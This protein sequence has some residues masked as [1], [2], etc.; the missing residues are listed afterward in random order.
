MT[1]TS[2]NTAQGA[3]F[4]SPKAPARIL[5]V[6]DHPIVRN[7]LVQL[8]EQEQDLIVCA[9]AGSAHEAE[10]ALEKHAPHIAMLDISLEG[11]NGIEL[12]RRIR[13]LYPETC[14][15]IL[16]MHDEN[17]YAKRA[18][19]AGARGYVTKQ[20]PPEHVVDAIRQVLAGTLYVSSAVAT[21]IIREFA[22]GS[23]AQPTEGGVASLSD[24][25][26]QIFELIG[27][28]NSTREIAG[29]LSLSPKTIESHRAH[30][31]RKLNIRSSAELTHFAIRFS[32]TDR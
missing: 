25:E 20:E 31:K 27:S 14:V 5:V 30:I 1:E 15:L 32:E 26:L 6:D 28:G 2:A 10:Q 12:T 3:R 16:S 7:G 9:E 13:N 8:I 23:P 19:R 21:E 29:M 18:L 22:D 4:P 24:R 17:L 11:T